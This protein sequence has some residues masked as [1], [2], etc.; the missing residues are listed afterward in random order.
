MM[1]SKPPPKKEGKMRIR[2]FPV[3]SMEQEW[4]MNVIDVKATILASLTDDNGRKVRGKHLVLIEE[5]YSRDS[6]EEQLRAQL[7]R[8]I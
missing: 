8:I 2:A 7:R 6:E 4:K 3:S 5:R 1:N